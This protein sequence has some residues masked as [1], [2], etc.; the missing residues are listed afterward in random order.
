MSIPVYTHTQS[1]T[2]LWVFPSVLPGPHCSLTVSQTGR[3]IKFAVDHVFAS[4]NRARQVKNRIAVVVTDGKSQDDVVNVPL[5]RSGASV[6]P[7]HGYLGDPYLEA[8]E[9]QGGS[10]SQHV[11]ESCNI[12][13]ITSLALFFQ[14]PL[15]GLNGSLST[16]HCCLCL[17]RW[18]PVWRPELRAL[19]CLLLESAVRSPPQSWYPSPTGRHLPM[20]YTPKI[21]PPLTSFKVPWSRSSVKVDI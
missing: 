18:M 2:A 13:N 16:I 19:Q 14:H 6:K 3:A 8:M 9:P 10:S 4:S 11:G 12:I 21:T 5:L 15:Y 1:L 7:S 20:S 17:L